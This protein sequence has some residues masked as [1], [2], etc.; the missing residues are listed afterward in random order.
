MT[1]LSQNRTILNHMKKL[2][3]VCAVFLFSNCNS[4]TI[5][6][7]SLAK[8]IKPESY[9]IEGPLH[10]E[11]VQDI[12][13][14]GS[15]YDELIITSPGGY[16][17]R[18]MIVVEEIIK[19]KYKISIYKLCVSA[20]AEYL[21]PAGNVNAKITF[22]EN[23]IVGFHWSAMLTEH[24]M[25]ENLQDNI[26][27]CSFSDSKELIKLQERGGTNPN[28]WRETLKQLGVDYSEYRLDK[29]GCPE[30]KI[31][32]EN[33]Y[34]LPT[35]KQLREVY[36]LDFEG[37]VCADNIDTCAKTIDGIWAKGSRI[38]VGDEVYVSKGR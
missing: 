7:P 28:N 17:S 27:H 38:V 5:E 23:P 20:C 25:R 30:I 14:L 33:E 2:L 18:A 36:L 34:W 32:F 24:I 6:T 10:D 22:I 29:D 12:V 1:T 16:P 31:K 15:R 13:S 37:G 9:I 4:G 21:L 8:H 26:D 3:V 11:F 35:S 19:R